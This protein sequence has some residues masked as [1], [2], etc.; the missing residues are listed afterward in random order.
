MDDRKII[1]LFFARS[2]TA[3]EAMKTKYGAR[4]QRLAGNLLRSREDG[5]ECINDALL[6]LWQR[7]PPEKPDHLWAYFSR[8][9]RNLCCSRLDH[10]CA[11]RRDR[12]MEVCMSELE[13]CFAT[14]CDPQKILESRQITQAINRFLDGLDATGRRIFVRRYY[15]FDS[16]ADIAKQLGMTRGAVNTRLS[17]LRA[18]LREQLEKEALFL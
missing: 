16:C 9:L 7:I 10:L 5:E 14:D 11:A 17:R 1:E 12:G 8:I 13:D 3:L 4:A 2:E 18:Q 6:A 15:Y